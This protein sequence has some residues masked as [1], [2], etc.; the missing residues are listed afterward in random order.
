[1]E[2]GTGFGPGRRQ[3]TDLL[4]GGECGKGK[5]DVG[6]AGRTH[7]GSLHI[8]RHHQHHPPPHPK[9]RGDAFEYEVHSRL[10]LIPIPASVFP[11]GRHCHPP[12]LP[13]HHPAPT[14]ELFGAGNQDSCHGV[15]PLLVLWLHLRERVF[16]SIRHGNHRAP[17]FPW[18]LCKFWAMGPVLPHQ[19]PGNARPRVWD[20]HM[21]AIFT[22]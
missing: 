7:F 9:R 10:V 12:M 11:T 6:A 22:L 4:D 20:T 16:L 8:L 1:M 5:G 18:E 19:L 13:R 2:R 14:L 21:P 3:D 15:W 17:S